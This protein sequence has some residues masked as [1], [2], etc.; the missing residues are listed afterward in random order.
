METLKEHLT[1]PWGLLRKSFRA[2]HKFGRVFE[3]KEKLNK[4]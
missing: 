1:S 4:G 2:T 3:G